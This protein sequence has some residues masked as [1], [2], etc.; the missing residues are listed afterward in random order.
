MKTRAG[1][2]RASEAASRS[3][4][5]VC[6]SSYRFPYLLHFPK[7]PAVL[8]IYYGVVI[9]YRRSKSLF[10]EIFCELSQE[11]QGVSETLP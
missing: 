5:M 11:K 1:L 8:K 2:L 4:P 3:T 6:C 9:Y 10:V 7:D